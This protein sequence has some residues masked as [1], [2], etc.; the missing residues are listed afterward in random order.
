M[1]CLFSL[2]CLRHITDVTPVEVDG[3]RVEELDGIRESDVYHTGRSPCGGLPRLVEPGGSRV[4]AAWQTPGDAPRQGQTIKA[5][6]VPAGVLSIEDTAKARERAG[7][8]LT[9][10]RES[11][12]KA[13]GG[14]ALR[15][16]QHAAA[17]ATARSGEHGSCSG[18]ATCRCKPGTQ[19]RA[20]TRT[21]MAVASS[22]GL[23]CLKLPGA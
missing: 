5:D 6:R 18:P 2:G 3:K 11:S 19:M 14:V 4:G 8:V 21:R 17:R 22:A 15:N 20:A 1:G 13:P 23:H 16:A 12:N 9:V 7:T 10:E